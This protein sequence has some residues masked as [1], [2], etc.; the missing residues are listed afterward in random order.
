MDS[1][2]SKFLTKITDTK[3]RRIKIDKSAWE[4]E[5]IKQGDIVEVTINKLKTGQEPQNDKKGIRCM[6]K[7]RSDGKCQIDRYLPG[8]MAGKEVDIIPRE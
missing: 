1:M 3:Q 8:E 2:A 4:L 6:V 7:A 5:D